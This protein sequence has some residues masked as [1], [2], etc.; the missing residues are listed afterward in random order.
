MYCIRLSRRLKK[1]IQEVMELSVH[2]IN[3][4]MA[5]DIANSDEFK[6]KVEHEVMS[7]E[8]AQLKKEEKSKMYKF[9]FEQS[10]KG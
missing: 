10:L 7:K 9:I 6:K 2:E 3:L 8:L 4:Q 1:T 5:Y